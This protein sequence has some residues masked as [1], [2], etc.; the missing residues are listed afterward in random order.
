M[1][2]ASF[3]DSNLVIG[4]RI[5]ECRLNWHMSQK[6]LARILRSTSNYISELECGRRALSLPI[7]KQLCLFFG[8]TYDYLYLGMDL[9]IDLLLK[10]AESGSQTKHP[11]S[12]D[13]LIS[14]IAD[15]SEE[16]CRDYL[17]LLSSARQILLQKSP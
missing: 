7:A 15:S 4:S 3:N 16:D 12:K 1:K 10:D 6:D 2:L 17:T 13:L 11:G 9:S 8:I 14:L 5:R